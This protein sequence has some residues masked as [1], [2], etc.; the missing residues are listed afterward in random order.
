M[1]QAKPKRSYNVFI[2]LISVL[3]GTAL[4]YTLETNQVTQSQQNLEQTKQTV[5]EL[6]LVHQQSLEQ[7]SLVNI[8]QDLTRVKEEFQLEQIKEFTLLHSKPSQLSFNQ[9]Q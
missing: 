3:L 1:K 9:R 4:C 5:K 8:T 6:T 7:L 2:V